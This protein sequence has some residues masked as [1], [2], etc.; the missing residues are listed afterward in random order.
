MDPG[1]NSMDPGHNTGSG[2]WT[3]AITQGVWRSH[4]TAVLLHLHVPRQEHRCVLAFPSLP[5]PSLLWLQT[6]CTSVC[7][8]QGAVTFDLDGG[9]A[10]VTCIGTI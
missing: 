9:C 7:M 2:V 4:L 3:L 8:Q 6:T 10:V 1:H 5:F